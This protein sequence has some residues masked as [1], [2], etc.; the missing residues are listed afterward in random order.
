MRKTR[1]TEFQIVKILN[2][3]EGG[4]AYHPVMMLM[5]SSI[6]TPRLN[7]MAD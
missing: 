3:T 6:G 2:A 4:A 5:V 7:F 1:F